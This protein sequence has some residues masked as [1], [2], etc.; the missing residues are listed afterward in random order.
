MQAD[1]SNA[2]EKETRPDDVAV[3]RGLF[4]DGLYSLA[5]KELES[6]REKGVHKEDECAVNFLLGKSHFLLE[7]HGDAI[8][9]LDSVLQKNCPIDDQEEARFYLG[10]TLLAAG[11]RGRAKG[12]LEKFKHLYP[13]SRFISDVE[14]KLGE[15]V[16]AESLEKFDA[17][18]YN[19]A[20]KGFE[21]VEG[22]A[23][24]G[25]PHGELFAKMGDAYFYVADYKA[26]KGAYK[27]ALKVIREDEEKGRIS[28]QLATIK[29]KL[30]QFDKAAS[31]M[32]RFLEDYP[33]HTLASR[34]QGS[35]LWALYRLE[36]YEETLNHLD[37]MREQGGSEREKEVKGL[38]T[39]A[40]RLLFLSDYPEAM[41][42]LEESLKNFGEDPLNGELMLLLAASYHG[43]GDETMEETTYGEI[44]KRY[45][46]SKTAKKSSFTLGKINFA[47][48]FSKESIRHFRSFLEVDALGPMADDAT[49]YL[50]ESLFLSGEI[51]ES[52]NSFTAL[53]RDFKESDH[54]FS[55]Y[56][57]IA[58]A[59]ILTGRHIEAARGY[60][61]IMK[62]F[63]GQSAGEDL[64]L[65]AAGAF[66]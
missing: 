51:E 55:A 13:E 26:A 37:S 58:D 41:G 8:P 60:G 50:A 40:S 39:T 32:E 2:G 59:D 48:G 62:N 45:P 54:L 61:F 17:Q 35:I 12:H 15:I 42:L 52:K 66:R 18:K 36:K 14:K 10:N 20:I 22:L 16:Y 21:K 5:L 11:E 43:M 24:D 7:R 65:K 53:V 31:D 1:I 44:I 49:Y 56:M 4:R 47:K 38:W 19:K 30:G 27:K 64:L 23:L 3:A 29:Y 25:V 63:P 34:A 28:F 9:N 46:S 6:Y 33:E 57:R